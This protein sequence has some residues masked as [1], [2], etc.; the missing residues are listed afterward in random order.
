MGTELGR[1]N[2]QES[3][4][5]SD[6]S[7]LNKFVHFSQKVQTF[8]KGEEENGTVKDTEQAAV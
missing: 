8:Q 1:E 7:T 3:K 2:L 4:P 6:T 5:S